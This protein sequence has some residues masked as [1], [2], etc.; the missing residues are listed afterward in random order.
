MV[1]FFSFFF[2]IASGTL[3][4]AAFNALLDELGLVGP[5]RVCSYLCV[6]CLLCSVYVCVRVRACVAYSH[7]VQHIGSG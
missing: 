4:A 2:Y 7:I 6:L 5:E 3:D 1:N